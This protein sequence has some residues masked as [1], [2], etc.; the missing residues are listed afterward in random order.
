MAFDK[1]LRS[2]VKIANRVTRSVQGNV[3]HRA[4]IAQDGLGKP[5]FDTEPG[6][7]TPRKAIVEKQM[8]RKVLPDGQ[9]T[10]I[11]AVITFLDQIP[12]QGSQGRQE[13]IDTRDELTLFDG[14]IG[15][16][17]YI[18]SVCDPS[19]GPDQYFQITVWIGVRWTRG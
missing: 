1:I 3:L 19:K 15:P 16:I 2:G 10:A 13:P 11:E 5:I 7:G 8:Q 12:T 17:A 6:E 18:D 4:W 9:M 14:S